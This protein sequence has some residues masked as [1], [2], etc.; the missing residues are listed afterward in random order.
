MKRIIAILCLLA[1]ITQAQSVIIVTNNV[2][3]LSA[4]STS[5]AA[6]T[7]RITEYLRQGSTPIDINNNTGLVFVTDIRDGA[8]AFSFNII[9]TNIVTTNG[10]IRY[11]FTLPA[12]P[13]YDVRTFIYPQDGSPRYA[14]GIYS[15]TVT[16]APAASSAT[17]NI[18]LTNDITVNATSTVS[19]TSQNIQTNISSLNITMPSANITVTGAVTSVN[20]V[21]GAVSLTVASTTNSAGVASW[22]GTQLQIGTNVPSGG[23][24]G[25]ITI[26][27][28]TTNVFDFV[29]QFPVTVS[30]IGNTIYFGQLGGGGT[31]IP[32]GNSNQVFNFVPATTQTFTV[33]SGVT[34]LYAYAWGAA[35]AGGSGVSGGAGGYS[36]GYF[37]VTNGEVLSVIIGEGGFVS[38]TT[39]ATSVSTNTANPF[40]NGGWGASKHTQRAGAGG[41]STAILRG[42][43]YLVV[44]G[45]G[46]GS[47]GGAGGGGGGTSGQSGFQQAGSTTGQA[48]GGGTQ[49]A[50]GSTGS[51]IIALSVTNTAGSFYLGGNGGFTTNLIAIG[52]GGGGGGFYG[53]GGGYGIVNNQGGGGGSGYI[54]SS[55][56]VIGTTVQAQ[57]PSA[58]TSATQP[59][60]ATDDPL[61]GSPTAAT[62][63]RAGGSTT[64]G[65]N[66]GMI[67]RWVAP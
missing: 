3:A 49:S 43:N 12:G 48:G 29:G 28:V 2:L 55:Q 47:S 13:T 60:P 8:P 63:G 42:T 10:Q 40:P 65:S 20:G 21:T 57:T 19:L 30:N 56:G 11:G 64:A 14:S 22:N 31:F 23:G 16:S 15:L 53:G 25:N 32:A 26:E 51:G 59:P 9:G 7:I 36:F 24:S 39:T 52:S 33:P 54:N 58:S 62:W 44:A 38:S 46:G 37:S 45:G 17:V 6:G 18:A 34:Q 35:G 50:G 1:G 41:G 27:G 4:V 5:A 66:G 61:Y 67:I